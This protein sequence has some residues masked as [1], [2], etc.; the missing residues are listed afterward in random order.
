MEKRK[1]WGIE[2]SECFPREYRSRWVTTDR[3]C[4]AS[5]HHGL[6]QRSNG[7]WVSWWH[8]KG[9]FSKYR[10]TE[11]NWLA[12][13][14]RSYSRQAWALRT[15]QSCTIVWLW[16]PLLKPGERHR[17]EVE[18]SVWKSRS[19]LSLAGAHLTSVLSAEMRSAS[20]LSKKFCLHIVHLNNEK[21]KF[22]HHNKAHYKAITIYQY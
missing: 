9:N 13:L 18:K 14:G 20:N 8:V 11:T 22:Y 12:D 21:Y 2:L 7:V 5:C 3:Y 17:Q 4:D 6:S 16:R 15:D 10:H 19:L 1:L